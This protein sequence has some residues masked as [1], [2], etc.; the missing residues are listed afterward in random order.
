MNPIAKWIGAH[1]NNFEKGGNKP[2][3]I[4]LHHIVGPQ[5]AADG[6]FKSPYGNGTALKPNP[7]SA[8]YSVGPEIHQYVKETD[9]A[10]A[11]GYTANR[12]AISI[13]HAGPP[14]SDKT[15]AN[16]AKLCADICKRYGWSV[17]YA[18]RKPRHRDYVNTVCPGDLDVKRIK[19]ETSARME[20]EL[21]KGHGIK[22]WYKR[23]NTAQFKL[24]KIKAL[25]KKLFKLKE[26]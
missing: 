8:T 22:Y 24:A 9:I 12:I 26:E 23:A 19:K 7:A 1:P 4:I 18:F 20:D 13:E 6:V 17:E 11:Q 10:Y 3:R 5:S 14:Y 21:Y 15:Y 16:S 25:V 2:N